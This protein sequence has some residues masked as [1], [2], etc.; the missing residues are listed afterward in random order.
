M[1]IKDVLK[2]LVPRR[3]DGAVDL[4]VYL[5]VAIAIPQIVA[6]LAFVYFS[7]IDTNPP[8]TI[9]S[10]PMTINRSEYHRGDLILGKLDF[11]V[12]ET[13]PALIN[14]TYQDGWELPATP[15]VWDGRLPGCYEDA[16]F[17]HIVPDSLPPGKYRLQVT[18][19]YALNPLTT[20][21]VT[22]HSEYFEVLEDASP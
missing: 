14:L 19:S 13:L 18:A 9:T 11:C 8:I 17:T 12:T 1:T 2:K 3:P 10:D 4:Y 22:W 21:R 20:R 5:L 6:L 16:E 7:F 15:F